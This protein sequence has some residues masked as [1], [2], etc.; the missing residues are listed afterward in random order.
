MK[1]NF[2]KGLIIGKYV[3]R[4]KDEFRKQNPGIQQ[5]D[6]Q[7][8]YKEYYSEKVNSLKKEIKIEKFIK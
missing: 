3:N 1:E 5:R 4:L 8:Q 6:F 7:A 2:K